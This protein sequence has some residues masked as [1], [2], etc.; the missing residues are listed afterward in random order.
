M[1]GLDSD[2]SDEDVNG[3]DVYDGRIQNEHDG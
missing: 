2:D 1:Y 3:D